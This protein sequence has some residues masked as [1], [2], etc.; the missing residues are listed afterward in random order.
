MKRQRDP[1]LN[2]GLRLQRV[3]PT[4]ICRRT[5]RAHP[6]SDAANLARS[7]GGE[8]QIARK[9]IADWQPLLDYCHG[10]PLTLRVIVGQAIKKGLRGKAQIGNFVEAIRSGEQAIE[11]GLTG[12]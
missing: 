9:D 10:N 1:Q 8:Q 5:A 4:D 12:T 2:L 6:N 7:L 11:G 3:R